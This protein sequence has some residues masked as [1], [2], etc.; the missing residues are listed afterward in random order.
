M[1]IGIL[2]LGRIGAFH[3]ET[4]SGLDAVESL[5]VSDPFT[6][7]AKAAAERFGAEVA[8]SPET[9]L[10]AGVDGI[11]VAAATDAHPALLLAGVSAGVP[12]FCEKPVARTMAEGVEVLRA[13]R[14]SGVPI[15]IGYNRR[16]DAG[17]A[18]ARAAVRSGELGKLHTVRSTTLDPAPPP[19]AYIAA[20]GGIFRDC[21]VHDF[22]VIRWVTGREVAEVYAV[23]GNRGADYIAAA[24]DCD[25]A[26]ALLTLDDGTI[27]VVSNSRHNA[28]GYDVRMELHGFADS[29]AVGLDDK[30]PLRS[31]EPGVA[32]P[33]GTPHGF[34]MDRFTEAYRAELAAFTEVVSGI[35][36]SPC[37]IEEALE[38]GWIAEACTLSLHEHRP[39][40][41]AEVKGA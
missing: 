25:T 30:V 27:A 28:R 12:V 8:D 34:F 26:G 29:L 19:A 11:V 20:S 15:Q 16:F 22:D 37:T 5:V 21:S 13:V 1:R 23:G 18:A 39:V 40:T 41:L 38:A 7:A 2:G 24:G 31:A 32:F 36:P 35:R 10:A 4:L 33:S 3:A 17:F 9:V 6:D 14:E